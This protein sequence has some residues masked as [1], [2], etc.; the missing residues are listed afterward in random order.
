MKLADWVAVYGAVVASAVAAW[1]LVVHWR[2]NRPNLNVTTSWGWEKGTPTVEVHVHVVNRGRVRV[3]W[4]TL[5][6]E[7]EP[8]GSRPI[9]RW[10]RRF[11]TARF[12]YRDGAAF[13]SV[14]SAG[15]LA[16]LPRWMEPGE[17]LMAHVKIPTTF[18]GRG[19]MWATAGI[20]TGQTFYCVVDCE[21]WRG[22]GG[23]AET[24][25]V[26][27]GSVSAGST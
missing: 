21:Y 20:S 7:A 27:D 13:R 5:L 8:N 11:S 1:Q 17:A 18:P 19:P 9:D 24:V 6:L 14:L 3:Q 25:T 26:P 10:R 4:G 12:R 2:S 16:D 22:E 15:E 23:D